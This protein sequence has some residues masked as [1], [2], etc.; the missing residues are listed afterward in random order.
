MKGIKQILVVLA[1]TLLITDSY[2]QNPVLK[3]W[4][5]AIPGSVKNDTYSE[6]VTE[7]NGIPSRYEKVTDPSLTV[8]LPS[9]E[10]ATEVTPPVCPVNTRSSRPVSASQRRTV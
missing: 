1:L 8:F 10:K 6:K 3:V 7:S 5:N 4:P 2:S 9:A